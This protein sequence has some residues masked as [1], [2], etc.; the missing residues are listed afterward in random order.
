MKI[1]EILKLP[2]KQINDVPLTQ[3]IEDVYIGDLLSF[4]IANAKE[5]TLWLTVQK[6]M[7]VIA[8]AELNDFVGIIFVQDSYPD[9]DAIQKATELGIPLFLSHKDA[10]S[11]AKDLMSLGL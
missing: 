7:N 8:I 1:S 3:D 5:G 10:Y 11:T 4:V 9:E 2:L 6:H